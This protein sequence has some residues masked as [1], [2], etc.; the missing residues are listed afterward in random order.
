MP[1][2]AQVGARVWMVNE[3]AHLAVDQ[4]IY[5]NRALRQTGLLATRAGP[6]GEQLDTYGPA[7]AVC[8]HQLAHV[9]VNETPILEKTREVLAALPGVDRVCGA[10]AR[11]ELGLDH[12]RA[13]D[14]VA[15]AKPNTWFAYPF[16]LDDSQAP[17][18][19]RT[20]DIHRKPG[21]DPCELFFDPKFR[22]PKG[23]VAPG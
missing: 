7:L 16:W 8:D 18:Y 13:G 5:I 20:V 4:P 3:Y 22:W 1:A 15:M 11:A 12:P 17:D 14:L 2:A 6:F 21:Y 23:R 10:E 19:A 9:Y